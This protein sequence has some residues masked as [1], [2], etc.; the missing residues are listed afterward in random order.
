MD[1]QEFMD[2][3]QAM[4]DTL[5]E[6]QTMIQDQQNQMQTLMSHISQ[7]ANTSHPGSSMSRKVKVAPP[8]YF[9]GNRKGSRSFLLQL[10]NIF[11]AQPDIFASDT[12]KV[13][14][15]ISFLRDVAFSWVAPF[16]ESDTEILHSFRLFEEKFLLT[17]GDTDRERQA[18]REL[19]SLKQKNRPASA[20]VA[21]FQRLIMDVHWPNASLFSLFYQALND[22]VKDEICKCDR[23]NNIE[24]YYTLA[25]RIDNRLFERRQEKRSSNRFQP[26]LIE[27]HDTSN[28][29]QES[30]PMIIGSTHPHSSLSTDERQRRIAEGLCMY[31]GSKDHLIASCPTKPK[32]S[33][34]FPARR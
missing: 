23:P 6:Q 31:C 19:L 17:F 13:A 3:F 11:R 1:P 28:T 30:E 7:Q 4:Q 18:E 5:R 10:K 34:N 25:V 8:E 21:D 32:R 24:D 15:A 9:S 14:Y 16:I 29:R 26:R 33:K 20:L 22:D 2:N 27:F 12:D